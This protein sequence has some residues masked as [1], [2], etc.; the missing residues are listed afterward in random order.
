MIQHTPGKWTIKP[1]YSQ[2]NV[3]R[4]WDEDGNYHADWSQDTMDANA[5]LMAAAPSLLAALKAA[6]HALTLL[7]PLGTHHD[8]IA[9]D[10]AL[11]LAEGRP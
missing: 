7:D 6:S 3:Y 11:N 1:D 9:I 4:L 8:A 10:E 2:E 5:R